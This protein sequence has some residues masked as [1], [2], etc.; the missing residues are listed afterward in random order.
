MPRSS[1]L[2]KRYG[3]DI[4]ADANWRLAVSAAGSDAC[5][6]L[7]AGT[8]GRVGGDGAAGAAELEAVT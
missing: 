5:E 6:A 1:Y 4:H 8:A 2:S 3:W 7:A